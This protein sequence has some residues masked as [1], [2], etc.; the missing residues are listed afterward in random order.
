MGDGLMKMIGIEREIH[1]KG[2][3]LRRRFLYT[4]G[5]IVLSCNER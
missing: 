2:L 4:K 3:A 5:E 1:G